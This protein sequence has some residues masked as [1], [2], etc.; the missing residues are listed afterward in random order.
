M[1]DVSDFITMGEAK[2][3]ANLQDHTYRYM[4]GLETLSFRPYL[5]AHI[6]IDHTSLD[7]DG[8]V[9]IQEEEEY[10]L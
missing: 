7:D 10:L 9:I 4:N 3:L 6:G 8:N 2:L 5:H 1:F